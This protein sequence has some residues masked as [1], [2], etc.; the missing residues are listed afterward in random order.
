VRADHRTGDQEC[1]ALAVSRLPCTVVGIRFV[2]EISRFLGIVIA[3]FYRD[4]DPPHF[5]A[6]HGE[7]EAILGIRDGVL[8]RGSLPGRA[9]GHVREWRLRHV[10]E[11]EVNW[12]RAKNRQ[13]LNRI[14]PLE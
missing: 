1:F 4:H 10:A 5:H 12:V 2:P 13:P 7:Y 3:M 8:L 14:A 11:L 9:L 6:T